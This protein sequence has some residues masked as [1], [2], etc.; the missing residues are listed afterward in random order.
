M[1][2]RII[3]WGLNLH[4]RLGNGGWRDSYRPRWSLFGGG[5]SPTTGGVRR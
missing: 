2:L 3:S 1:R 5:A 4:G